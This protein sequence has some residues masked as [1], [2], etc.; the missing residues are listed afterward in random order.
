MKRRTEYIFS[1]NTGRSGS[2]YLKTLFDNVTDCQ[3]LHE[4]MPV[5][6]G[7]VMRKYSKGNSE[8]MRLIARQK[9]EIAQNV[10]R[11]GEIYF[12][13]NHCFIKGF[14]WFLPELL[15][16]ENIGVIILKRDKTE[17]AWSY[18]RI[19]CSPL[20]RKGRKWLY[21]PWQKNSKVAP[22]TLS[23]SARASYFAACVVK[24]ICWFARRI[25]KIPLQDP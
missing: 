8:P 2:A 1:I 22:P 23:F 24:F 6:N 7:A 4:P 14:G 5:G 13:S 17:I 20:I 18:L 19:G 10:A 21:T 9:A 12:E 15:G 16:E 11:T 25:F 3:S